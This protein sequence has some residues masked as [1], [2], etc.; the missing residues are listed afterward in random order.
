MRSPLVFLVLPLLLALHGR[1]LDAQSELPPPVAAGLAAVKAG[2]Y[3]SAVDEWTKAWANSGRADSVRTAFKIG[4]ARVIASGNIPKGWELARDIAVGKTVH[5]YYIV[6]LGSSDPVFLVLQ[7]YQR[8]DGTWTIDHLAF[9][10]TMTALS[11]FDAAEF[12]RSQ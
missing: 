5:R 2:N 8:P 10:T 11:P 6:I 1:P 7:A 12:P 9:N 4:F 3:D